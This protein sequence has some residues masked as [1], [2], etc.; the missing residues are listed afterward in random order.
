MKVEMLMPQ[1]GE[2]I[3][4]ATV[5]KWLKG[6]GDS[7]EK[8]E[9]IL[10]ISTDKVDSE[11][12]APASGVLVEIMAQEE[13][14]VPVKTVVAVIETE[15]SNAAASQPSTNG[16]APSSAKPEIVET[17]KAEATQTSAPV[18]GRFYTPVVKSIAQQH[19]LSNEDLAK[20]KGT[21]A[22]GRVVKAD[23]LNYIEASK[24]AATTSAAQQVVTAPS[25]TP[26][27]PTARPYHPAAGEV[28]EPM[29]N[30]RKRIAEHMVRSKATS[31][32]V[33]TVQEADVTNI[34]R[35]RKQ[36]QSAFVAR[37]GYKL[38]FTPFFLE[39][40]TRA[41]VEFPYI[42]AS[43]NGNDIILK[44]EVNLGCAVALG[45]TGL[46]V[47]VIKRA[48][49]LNLPGIASSL[50]DLATRAR[51]K[52]LEPNDVQGGTFTVTNVG[53]FGSIIGYPIISQ[54]Q[55][56]ILALGAIKK[57]PVVVNDMIAV[58]DIVYLTLSYDHRLIDGAMA[59]QFL[60]Y[61]TQYLGG[62]DMERKI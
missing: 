22:Q 6:V 36:N 1:M 7:V 30:M 19:G 57:R 34:A 31:P 17:P 23:L 27:Q 5:L 14:T 2:S 20:V 28:I 42:N 48:D 56:G 38:S 45:T 33:Y 12:P 24:T 3:T 41:L 54:P 49:Q 43:I 11:I 61:I 40:T 53:T 26:S 25:P 47:P 39:A 58:R 46:V 62:W 15:A 8:D 50:N 32:H 37:Y 10:E 35:W 44:Q 16:S 13:E 60:R 21:G 29:D 51:N 4:E 55:L 59:G 52:Q 18:D 9:T